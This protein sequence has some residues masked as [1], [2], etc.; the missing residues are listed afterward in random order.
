MRRQGA[1]ARKRRG[2]LGRTLGFGLAMVVPALVAG[3]LVVAE[4]VGVVGGGKS[5]GGVAAWGVAG[6]VAPRGSGAS[7]V[8]VV[9]PLVVG[10]PP[11]ADLVYGGVVRGRWAVS[12]ARWGFVGVEER[13]VENARTFSSDGRRVA[14]RV[15]TSPRGEAP[16]REEWK[17][18]AVLR[19]GQSAGRRG[20]SWGRTAVPVRE[21]RKA[22][23]GGG[24]CPAEWRGTWLW[25]EK[26]AGGEGVE[27]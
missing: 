7:W 25:E 6:A 18:G 22:P 2:G 13:V 21:T 8:G 17:V 19:L 5:G 10:A 12:R 23:I 1:C 4:A 20:A 15:R 11:R 26:C 9:E 27:R 14:A 3:G 16:V 24:G